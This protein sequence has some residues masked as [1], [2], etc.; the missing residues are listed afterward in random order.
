MNV[1][2][3]DVSTADGESVQSSGVGHL[4]DISGAFVDVGG[5]LNAWLTTKKTLS[6]TC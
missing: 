5:M 3:C 2:L 1:S 4:C 6:P